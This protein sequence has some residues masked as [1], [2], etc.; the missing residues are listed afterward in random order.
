MH[1]PE[2]CGAETTTTTTAAAAA[3]TS[4]AAKQQQQGSALLFN[5]AGV[6]LVAIFSKLWVLCMCCCDL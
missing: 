4:V 3:T 5:H 2:Q 6:T 1:R